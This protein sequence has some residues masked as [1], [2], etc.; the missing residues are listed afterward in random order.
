[1]IPLI[2]RDCLWQSEPVLKDLQALP[3]NGKAV[4]TFPAATGERETA[5]GRRLLK[6]LKNSSKQ[7]Q[8]RRQ[9]IA[10]DNS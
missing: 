9:P 8:R 2:A 4:I 6:L 5:Y 7:K 3:T 1:M 10:V